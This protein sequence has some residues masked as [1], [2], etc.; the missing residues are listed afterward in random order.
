MEGWKLLQERI[1]RNN[2][3]LAPL[4][5][6]GKGR[7]TTSG[8]RTWPKARQQQKLIRA[9]WVQDGRQVDFG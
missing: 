5:Q 6:E 2:Q 7:G 4:T 3:S 8:R 1:E 9:K